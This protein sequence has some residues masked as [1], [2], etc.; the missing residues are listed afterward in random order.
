LAILTDLDSPV[1]Y[2]AGSELGFT[3]TITAPEVG[4]YYMLGALYD[5]DYAMIPGTMFG[6]LLPVD[7]AYALNN[8]EQMS[9]W[10]LEE[11]DEEEINC[12]FVFSR[13]ST[14]MGLF[15][16]SMVGD[17]ASLEDDVEV[18]STSVVLAGEVAV[19]LDLSTIVSAVVVI[20]MMGIMMKV[21]K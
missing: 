4:T 9:L 18:S 14:I 6:V 12:K 17:E 13:T 11:G 3:I 8:P 10:E 7:E 21:V 15:L 5:S 1:T 2:V 19:E 16:V 20:G